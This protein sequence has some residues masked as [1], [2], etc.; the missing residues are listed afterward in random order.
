MGGRIIDR[1]A[2]RQCSSRWLGF[3]LL[4]TGL[5][6]LLLQ[7]TVKDRIHGLAVLFYAM[8]P[9]V[10]VVAT[11][12]SVGLLS[13]RSSLR[14]VLVS[15]AAATLALVAWIRT[16][17]TYAHRPA[18][19]GDLRVVLWNLGDPR[20]PSPIVD[21]LQAADGQVV[22]LLESGWSDRTRRLF[23]KS[24]LSN[25][26]VR[27]LP[28]GA[29]LLSVYPVS[30]IST[31]RMGR[32]TYI[33]T[34]ELSTPSGPVWLVAADLESNLLSNR[35]PLIARVYELATSLRFPTIVL[36]DFNTPHTSVFFEGFR[37]SFR[38]AFASSGDGLIPTWPALLPV[39]GLDHVWLSPGIA[40]GHTRTLRTF[41]SDHAAVIAD[42][43]LPA[44]TGE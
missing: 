1:V 16:D 35:G 32:R 42:M 8:P 13:R 5:V 9:L 21:I 33:H 41:H 11:L 18:S 6:G 36:G 44:G 34:C 40:A 43:T 3:L 25:Y 7:Y 2:L 14:W 29:A 22:L 15:V 38:H 17:Y 19:A 39:L 24:H 27:F 31:H 10:I 26:T 28:G 23:W 4:A 37:G 12:L 20:N 30:K